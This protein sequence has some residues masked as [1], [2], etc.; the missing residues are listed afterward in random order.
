L[1]VTGGIELYGLIPST[2]WTRLA[3]YAESG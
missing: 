1:A 2:T 3:V